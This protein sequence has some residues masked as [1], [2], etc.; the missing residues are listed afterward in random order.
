MWSRRLLGKQGK[1]QAEAA[2]RGSGAA[3]RQ[4]S[5]AAEQQVGL[6]DEAESQVG[7]LAVWQRGSRAGGGWRRQYGDQRQWDS[8]QRGWCCNQEQRRVRE[9][10]GWIRVIMERFEDQRNPGA[11]GKGAAESGPWNRVSSPGHTGPSCKSAD[12]MCDIVPGLLPNATTN[13]RLS[14]G[15]RAEYATRGQRGP[16]ITPWRKGKAS[17]STRGKG[18]LAWWGRRAI[19]GINGRCVDAM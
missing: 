9:R 18:K 6:A 11:T 19:D 17:C 14:R 2:G 3:V 8:R 16:V 1:R 12:F 10:S 13:T 4:C 5:G 7:A 15:F